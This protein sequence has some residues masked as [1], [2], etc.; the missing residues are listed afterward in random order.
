MTRVLRVGS[1][2]YVVARPLDL[3]LEHEPG[4]DFQRAVPARLVE[5]LRD[6]SLDVALVSSIELFRR[7][8]YGYLD[9]PAV[10][11]RGEVRSVQVFLRRP[12]DEVREVVL[13]PSSRAAQ[14]LTRVVLPGRTE[15]E[16]SF[17]EIEPGRDPRQAAE[18]KDADA[19]LA[20]GDPA[21]RQA[22]APD[23]PAVFS[24]SAAWT[25]DTGLPFVFAVWIVRAGVEL[26]GAALQ[27]FARARE[28]GAGAL[29]SL[30]R[31]A[32]ETWDLPLEPCRRY[33]LEECRYAPDRDLGAALT[34]F[35]DAAAARSLCDGDFAPTPIPMPACRV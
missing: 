28:R 13:D 26:D 33:L 7:P 29:E 14:A 18:E 30:A 25:E 9:G 27:V 34:A 10:T 5:G 6:G 24:P 8:G 23:A 15:A 11:G 21:L 22:L 19:W 12:L 31:E 1:P 16:P 4:L 32:S 35:R 3:G 17:H 2:A 20:I